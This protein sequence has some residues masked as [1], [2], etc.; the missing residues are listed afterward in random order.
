MEKKS[1]TPAARI[2]A[3]IEILNDV[4]SEE[5]PADR[6]INYYLRQRR[7]MGSKDRHAVTDLTYKL[8]R[9]YYRL[10]WW[11]SQSPL[12][13]NGRTLIISYLM[14]HDKLKLKELKEFFY[15][16]QYTP[17]PLSSREQDFAHSL[18][19]KWLEDKDMPERNL[20]ECPEWAEA[21][22]KEAFGERYS[23]EMMAMREPAG[24]DLRVNTL[25]IER[26]EAI[27]KLREDEIDVDK[28]HLSPW[29]IR[30]ARRVAINKNELFEKGHI[31]VQDQGSQLIALIA[32][33]KPGEQVIDYCAG[34]G[35]KTLAM[36]MTMKNKG[37]IVAMDVLERRL[38]RAKKRFRRAGLHNIETRPINQDNQ[39]WIKRQKGKFDLVLADAPCSGSGTWRRD[40]DKR[41]NRIGPDLEELVPLQAEI[42]E[43]SSR[44]VKPGGRLVYGT[45]S[46]FEAEN[47]KQIE[48]FVKNNPDFEILN[49]TDILPDLKSEGPYLE[50]SSAQNKTD[51]F[52]A[53]LLKRKK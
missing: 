25:F 48:N 40:P 23:E 11:I 22:F 49:I 1:M 16:E 41:W 47:Q 44:L 42:L 6:V 27:E 4:F 3:V 13:I 20:L 35:G 31:E 43:K 33:A 7:Y 18:A 24:F 37:R 5:R 8:M 12:E 26:D 46:V 2:Q 28:G 51:G 52:F 15:L 53:A 9:H 30:V 50:L 32:D 36:G 14:L 19:G 17:Q 38:E 10:S 21:Y 39:K 45:C 34:A 29:G